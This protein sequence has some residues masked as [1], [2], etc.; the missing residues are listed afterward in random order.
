M[1]RMRFLGRIDLSTGRSKSSDLRKIP[2]FRYILEHPHSITYRTIFE[3]TTQCFLSYD[4]FVLIPNWSFFNFP[5]LLIFCPRS[6]AVAMGDI[7]CRDPR[8]SHSSLRAAS[9]SRSAAERRPLSKLSATSMQPIL[10][11]SPKIRV[12]NL[13]NASSGDQRRHSI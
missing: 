2:G 3:C 10:P 9:L 8:R 4:F 7:F 12:S 5:P 1:I 13:S 11:K 6:F